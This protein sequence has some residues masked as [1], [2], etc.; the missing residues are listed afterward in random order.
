[1]KAMR[2][3]LRQPR[4]AVVADKVFDMVE[5]LFP[6]AKEKAGRLYKKENE[7]FGYTGVHYRRGFNS[8]FLLKHSLLAGATP[9]EL[10]YSLPVEYFTPEDKKILRNYIGYLESMFEV[11][12]IADNRRDYRLADL[13]DG[14]RYNVE[15]VD[16]PDALA[17][18]DILYATLVKKTSG[19]YFFYGNAHNHGKQD[20][21]K[22]KASLKEAMKGQSKNRR[23]TPPKIEW[24][25]TYKQPQKNKPKT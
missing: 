9:A 23:R 4:E 13:V 8:W 21:Q 16:M 14:R 2:S 15:T 17:E 7:T 24:E 25:I 5:V 6:G 12:A 18:G 3:R 20:T 11:E 19:A 10:A 1:M 22:L